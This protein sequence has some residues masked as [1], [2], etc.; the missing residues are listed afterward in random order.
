M[1]GLVSRWVERASVDRQEEDELR[2]R[3]RTAG[4][5]PVAEAR[6]RER[7]HVRGV[8]SSVALRPL[9]EATSLEAELYDG[10]GWLTLVWLGR[11][12]IEGITPGRS[13][14][15]TGRVGLRGTNERVMY[16]PA[17]RLDES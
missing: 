11:R 2:L 14:R 1:A 10:T 12:R 15:A 5:T 3:T 17:Y 4:C 16:N 13:L 7:A 9:D 6:V 8:L